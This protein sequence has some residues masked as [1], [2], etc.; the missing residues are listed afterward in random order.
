MKIVANAFVSTGVIG[1]LTL[2]GYLSGAKHWMGK[3]TKAYVSKF[4]M[5]VAIPFMCIY[6]LNTNLTRDMIE[7]SGKLLFIPLS[8]T[9]CSFLMSF[10]VGK[11]LRMRK[12]RLGVFMTMCALSNTM[13]VGYAMCTELFGNECIPYVMLTYLISSSATQS[14]GIS[15]IRWSGGF[16]ASSKKETVLKLISSPTII[17]IFAALSFVCFKVKVPEL[18][19]SFGK[20]MS[21]IVVPL[22][23]II[24]G[25]I[26]YEIGLKN[27][28][29][30]S[31]LIIVMVFRFLVCPLITATLCAL[32]DVDGLARSVLLIQSAMPVV[33]VAVI[34]SADYKA[35][36]KF[37]AQ[38]AALTTLASFVIIPLLTVV[39]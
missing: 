20:Y 1:L 10:F 28:C 23:M 25:Y 6:G 17:G 14:V 9:T 5:T 27:I 13:F 2:C 35:D 8:C 11:I 12:K 18:V 7:T 30:D 24:T 3:E 29:I 21:N 4:L 37:A 33:S 22:A 26:I 34:A 39:A 15:L 38:G 32:A 16:G 19:L 36:E 31:H